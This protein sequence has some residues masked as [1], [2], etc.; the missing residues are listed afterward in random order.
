MADFCLD[1]TSKS[2]KPRPTRIRFLLAP[3]FNMARVSGEINAS[4]EKNFLLI[5]FVHLRI[6]K[7]T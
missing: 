6:A 5:I 4:A 7:V 1:L 3:T 2:V